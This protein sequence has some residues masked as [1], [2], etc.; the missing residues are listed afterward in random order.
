[1]TWEGLCLQDK[2]YRKIK[3]RHSSYENALLRVSE[4]PNAVMMFVSGLNSP[5]L[6]RA[7]SEA[8]TN[9]NIRLV[10]VNDWDFNDAKDTRGN[11]IYQFVTIP[12]RTY[13]G[14]QKGFLLGSDVESIAVSAVLV[15][16]TDWARQYGPEALDALSYA[17]MES[18]PTI[19]NRTNGLTR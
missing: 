13:P 1:M 11:R 8:R 19:R 18:R 3:T 17:I 12:A 6:Q 15:V 14:L 5:L 7:E 16:R 9:K 10:Q 2:S 4:D